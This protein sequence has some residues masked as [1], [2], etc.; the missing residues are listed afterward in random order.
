VE[1]PCTSVERLW[2]TLLDASRHPARELAE[3]YT[4]RWEVESFFSELKATLGRENLLR[5]TSLHGA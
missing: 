3:L 5:A 1:S 4:Q 2:T